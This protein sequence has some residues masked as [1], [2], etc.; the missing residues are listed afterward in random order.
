MSSNYGFDHGVLEANVD[1]RFAL[2]CRQRRQFEDPG[3]V[4]KQVD[5]STSFILA[6]R[7][8]K[9]IWC[10]RS[11]LFSICP[12]FRSTPHYSSTGRPSIDPELMIRMLVVGYVYDPLGVTDLPEVNLAYRWFHRLGYRGRYPGPFGIF[13]R[14]DERFRD[15]DWRQPRVP[16]QMRVR[17]RLQRRSAVP[18][19]RP[20][21]PCLRR[22]YVADEFLGYP[23]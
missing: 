5:Y 13:A 10:V 23:S 21:S 6:T 14:R 22:L 9:I 8:L 4:G 15:G 1:L 12:G 18:H 2:G 20:K 16:S 7:F 11:T 19:W 3:S 17:H